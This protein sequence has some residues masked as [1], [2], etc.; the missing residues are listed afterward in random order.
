MIA[1]F[2][3]AADKDVRQMLQK[4]AMGADKIVAQL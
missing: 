4:M 1:I 3:C 2:G